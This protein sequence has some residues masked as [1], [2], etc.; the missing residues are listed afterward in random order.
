MSTRR[1][2][3][4]MIELLTVV[5]IIA[6]LIALLLPAIQS[7][8]EIARRTQC[9]NNLLQ[10][11]IALGNYVSTHEVLPPGVVND[12]G[13]IQNVPR[14]YHFGWA[15][16]ILPFLEQRNLYRQFDF[17]HGLYEGRNVTVQSGRMSTFLCPST[18]GPARPTIWAVITTSRPRS[19]SITMASSSSIAT[20]RMTTSPMGRPI[21]SSSAKAGVVRRSVG[22]RGHGPRSAIPDLPSMRAISR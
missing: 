4:T 17:R 19:M 8:S 22:P 18:P 9:Q 10:L 11:G 14:G 2:G 21:P 3:F 1:P 12:K 13:P 15:V 5:A 16:Q 6:V 20:W 7:A